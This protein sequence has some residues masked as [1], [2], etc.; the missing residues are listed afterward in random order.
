MYIT[1]NIYTQEKKKTHL[2]LPF[3]FSG[4]CFVLYF[5]VIFFHPSTA[6]APPKKN[7][8]S[9]WNIQSCN[10][11]RVV[12]HSESNLVGDSVHTLHHWIV[13]ANTHTQRHLLSAAV[14]NY[15]D[16]VRNV[17]A[18]Q[19]RQ[20]WRVA[21]QTTFFPETSMISAW[22]KLDKSWKEYLVTPPGS[23]NYR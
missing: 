10:D 8:L 11:T 16:Y 17:H 1:F 14:Q 4:T 18:P 9:F 3:F 5:F 12:K 7:T 2:L 6:F 13:R 19:E 23:L 21:T 20:Q 22:R 15:N